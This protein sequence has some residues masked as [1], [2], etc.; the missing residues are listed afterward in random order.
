MPA[1]VMREIM[2][3]IV[4]RRTLI[5]VAILLGSLPGYAGFFG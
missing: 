3:N 1:Q 4:D 5:F 2:T